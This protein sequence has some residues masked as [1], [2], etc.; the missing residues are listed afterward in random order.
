[1]ALAA[2]TTIAVFLGQMGERQ[3]V[4]TQDDSS[5]PAE[6]E[7]PVVVSEK[8]IK[9]EEKV[10]KVNEQHNFSEKKLSIETDKTVEEPNI[11]DKN[12]AKE[13]LKDEVP[14]QK[15]ETKKTKSIPKFQRRIKESY[16]PKR[17]R[18]WIWTPKQLKNEKYV[19][20]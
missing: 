20:M 7:K 6:T 3:V 2:T 13:C 10:C 17:K 11:C 4:M 15:P 12:L 16:K 19:E 9:I 5:P 18:Y 14:E 1:M 8:E